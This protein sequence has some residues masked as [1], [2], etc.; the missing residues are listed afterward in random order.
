MEVYSTG[1]SPS[2][3][4]AGYTLV[5][6]DEFNDNMLNSQNWNVVSGPSGNGFESYTSDNVFVNN[7]YLT[8]KSNYQ[9]G[10]YTS[11]GVHTNRKFSQTYG[12]FEMRARIP[13]GLGLWNSFYLM[14]Q[15]GWP[16]EIDIFE[17]N[18]KWSDTVRF[19]THW[20]TQANPLS[21]GG[22]YT[23]PD[24][25][26]DFHTFAV[27]W[28]KGKIRWFVDNVQRYETD[29]DVPVPD[30]PFYININTAIGIAQWAGYP[31][32]STIFPQ[33]YDIDYVRVYQ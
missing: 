12:Y 18:G 24:F 16:P 23:G 25:S 30:T 19:A 17:N 28:Q 11:G 21:R 7:G 32:Q 2:T 1:L 33:Y 22:P 9:N 8:L 15:V 20:G 27:E 29:S 10:K 4:P 31:D 5:W 3:A 6:D 26:Q 13:K 14:P